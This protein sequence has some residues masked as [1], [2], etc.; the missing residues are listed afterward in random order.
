VVGYQVTDSGLKL[1]K[2]ID[3]LMRMLEPEKFE[4][5]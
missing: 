1:L 2:V 5:V 3:T 4:K